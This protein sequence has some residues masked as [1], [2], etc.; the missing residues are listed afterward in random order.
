MKS[1]VPAGHSAFWLIG[2][3][4]ISDVQERL[5]WTVPSVSAAPPQKWWPEDRS[6]GPIV[7]ELGVAATLNLH[8]VFRVADVILHTLVE[9]LCSD[10]SMTVH[11]KHIDRR[12]H[13]WY[14]I[15]CSKVRWARCC[16]EN[17]ALILAPH[18]FIPQNIVRSLTGISTCKTGRTGQ[19]VTALGLLCPFLQADWKR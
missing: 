11:Q 1:G 5:R 6:R 16:S 3:A 10:L 2:V 14:S 18:K 9:G 15:Y 8:S 17:S 4:L 13:T 19:K 7:A 12:R